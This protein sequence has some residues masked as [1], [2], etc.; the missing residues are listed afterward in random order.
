MTSDPV[1][2][3]EDMEDFFDLHRKSSP[4]KEDFM[5]EPTMQGFFHEVARFSLAQ[6]WLE[7]SF[8]LINGEKTATMLCFAYDNQTL[9]YNSG[10]DP[11]RFAYL[12]PGIVLL[13]Y[14]IQD[15]IAKGHTAFDF[16]RGD[17]VYKYRFGG[18]DSEIF[19]VTVRREQ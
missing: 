4:D 1:R 14:H 13:G 2:L 9:V 19:Q 18:Q 16:L 12:S 8:L 10:Y 7:L 5:S 11:Q 17:E 6:G 3:S 15:S